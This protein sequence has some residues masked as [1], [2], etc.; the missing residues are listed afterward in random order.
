MDHHCVDN[1]C[2]D[3]SD[4]LVVYTIHNDIHVTEA[5]LVL[6][7]SF[8]VQVDNTVVRVNLIPEVEVSNFK[9]N[10]MLKNQNCYLIIRASVDALM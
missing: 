7:V 6:T 1:V 2:T 3:V 10:E 9:A 5:S 4:G 8:L